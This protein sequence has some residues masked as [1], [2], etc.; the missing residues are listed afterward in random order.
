MSGE[1][2]G[3][4]SPDEDSLLAVA[5]V[6]PPCGERTVY[7]DFYE[8]GSPTHTHQRWALWHA[9][10]VCLKKTVPHLWQC[11]KNLQNGG[12]NT[13]RADSCMDYLPLPRCHWRPCIVPFPV[14]AAPDLG[15][16]LG[17]GVEGVNILTLWKSGASMFQVSVTCS[18]QHR[19][20]TWG[21]WPPGHND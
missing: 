4:R 13:S 8:L 6:S 17:E 15:K 2:T 14:K 9:P 11:S 10:H 7:L 18:L 20:S 21:L 3:K 12:F 5:S 1:T 16:R 19:F